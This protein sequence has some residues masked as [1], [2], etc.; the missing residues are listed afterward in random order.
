MEQPDTLTQELDAIA[1]IGRVLEN[2]TDVAARQ[3]VL[4]WAAERF[5][6]DAALVDV[7]GNVADRWSQ[8]A[9]VFSDPALAVD[10]PDDIFGIAG[11]EVVDDNLSL[12]E[13]SD[14]RVA[15]AMAKQPIDV[16][17]RSFAA[18]FQ[19]FAEEWNG[20]SA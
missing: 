6:S 13:P 8:P 20:A 12:D 9:A 1:A 18:D 3:R 19:R 15:E 14:T 5:M 2:L 4:R 7:P 16:V 11:G 17:I 10:L